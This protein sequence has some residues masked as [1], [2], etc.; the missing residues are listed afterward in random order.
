MIWPALLAPGFFLV[1]IGLP[2]PAE[3]QPEKLTFATLE[4]ETISPLATDTDQPIAI[5]FITVDCPIANAYAPEIGRIFEEFSPK[6]IRFLLVHV[7]PDLEV[8]DAREHASDYHLETP[9]VI[10][11]HHRLVTA[12][13]AT[14]TPEAVVLDARGKKVYQGRIDDLFTDFGTRRNRATQRDLR[15]AL[16]AILEGKP[17]PVSETEAIGCLMPLL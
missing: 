9:I 10:D 11:R 4:G 15:N 13:G 1:S 2:A 16:E 12:T 3:E 6:G 14:I 7:D 17:V 5:L 8:E